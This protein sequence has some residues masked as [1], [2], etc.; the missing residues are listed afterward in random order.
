V[1]DQTRQIRKIWRVF[2]AP[3]KGPA[4]ER[5]VHVGPEGLTGVAF[6]E[7]LLELECQDASMFC[8]DCAG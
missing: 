6:P 2:L 4:F 5:P 8:A 7:R 1:N 3:P